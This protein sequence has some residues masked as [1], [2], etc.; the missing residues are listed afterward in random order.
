MLLLKSLALHSVASTT[1]VIPVLASGVGREQFGILVGTILFF[2]A[3]YG[4]SVFI[5]RVFVPAGRVRDALR[6]TRAEA[7]KISQYLDEVGIK[8]MTFYTWVCAC[9]G[10]LMPVVFMDDNADNQ[11]VATWQESRRAM[12]KLSLDRKLDP[13]WGTMDAVGAV[14]VIII[15]ERQANGQGIY[16]PTAE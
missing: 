12:T 3:F 6:C 13:T 5:S 14:T 1:E 9:E 15:Q 11:F 16:M 8:W 10:K 7:K 2:A 4:L